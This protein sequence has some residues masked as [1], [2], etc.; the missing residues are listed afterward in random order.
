[1]AMAP[2]TDNIGVTVEGPTMKSVLEMDDLGDFLT[3]A[4]MAGR[5]FTSERE[6]YVSECLLLL[7]HGPP[8]LKCAQYFLCFYFLFFAFF[9][10]Y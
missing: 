2:G 5:E 3:Q 10:N 8:F 1:M 4:A 9:T 6:Q 7:Q